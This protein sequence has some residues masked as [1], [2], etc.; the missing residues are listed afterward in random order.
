M[1]VLGVDIGIT[2]GLALLDGEQAHVWPV[3]TLE[4]KINGKTKRRIDPDKLAR[5]ISLEALRHYEQPSDGV[6]FVEGA[7]ASPSMGV[8]SAFGYGESFGLVRGIL[9]HLG[10]PVRVV[11]P[12]KWKR[13]LGLIK[14]GSRKIGRDAAREKTS[15]IA[16]ARKLYP[17][18][19]AA[20]NRE[21][22]NGPAEALLLAHYGAETL[23]L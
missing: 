4:R 9:A 18:L 1:L 2:G 20:L 14:P 3:P 8:S 22:D 16:L 12:V 13:A 7:Q 21:K 15:S 10:V 19:H 23:G 5:L 11:S 6:A 17:H